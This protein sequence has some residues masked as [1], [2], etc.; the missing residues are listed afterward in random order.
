LIASTNGYSLMMRAGIA[1]EILKAIHEA[2]TRHPPK[3]RKP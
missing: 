2:E 1:A 3:A